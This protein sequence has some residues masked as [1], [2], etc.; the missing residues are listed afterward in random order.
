M[1]NELKLASAVLAALVFV[2]CDSKK[3]ETTT[4]TPPAA[5]QSNTVSDQVKNATS[6]VQNAAANAQDAAKNAATN[7]QTQ[8]NTAVANASDAAQAK[9]KQVADYIAQKK[10]DVA[11]S[12]LKEVEGMKSSLPEAVQTQI[13]ALRT[14]LDAAKASGG[15][16]SMPSMPK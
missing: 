9:L 8:A 12:T 1:R 10:F 11:D 13:T 15:G 2:G 6:N 3:D 14:Q 16:I 5:P 4:A 7:A